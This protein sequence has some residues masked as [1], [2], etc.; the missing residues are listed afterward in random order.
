MISLVIYG[1][2]DADVKSEDIAGALLWEFGWGSSHCKMNGMEII[3]GMASG[4]DTAGKRF[5]E[6]H[7]FPVREFPADWEKHGKAAGYIRNREMARVATHG[8]GFWKNESRGTAHMTSLLVSMGK[9][10]VLLTEW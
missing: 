6:K 1:S 8:L 10:V 2:R 4:A 3:C 7:G 9:P 5:G